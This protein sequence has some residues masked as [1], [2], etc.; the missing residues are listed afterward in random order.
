MHCESLMGEAPPSAE[1][2][3]DLTTPPSLT[4]GSVP[5]LAPPLEALKTLPLIWNPPYLDSS[6]SS[7][8]P[9]PRL[10]QPSP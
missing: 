3:R 9:F 10:T 5:A 4:L 7:L 6:V 8:S 1:D 2:T